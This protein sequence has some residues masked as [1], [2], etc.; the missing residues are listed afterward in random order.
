MV[1]ISCRIVV[2]VLPVFARTNS[3]TSVFFLLLLSARSSLSILTHS[4]FLLNTTYI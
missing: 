3:L 4:R 2:A 1:L